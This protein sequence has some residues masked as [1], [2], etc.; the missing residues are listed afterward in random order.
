MLLECV[1]VFPSH[2]NKHMS[3][4]HEQMTLTNQFFL[5][6]QSERFMENPQALK[7]NDV[8]YKMYKKCKLNKGVHEFQSPLFYNS[9]TLVPRDFFSKLFPLKVRC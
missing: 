5:M 1:P 4:I 2:N 3:L 8:L 6:S 7:C 9:W